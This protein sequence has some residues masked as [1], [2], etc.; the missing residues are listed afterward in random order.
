MTAETYWQQ[1]LE[2]SQSA[3]NS[4]ALV[5]LATDLDHLVGEAGITYELRHLKGVPPRHLRSA[6]P[7]PNPFR[8]WDRALEVCEVGDQHVLILNKYPVQIGHM[9]LITRQWAPQ[10]GWLNLK[11]WQALVTVDSNTTGLWFFNSGPAA[12][13]SQPHRHLQLLPRHPGESV[14]P[15]GDWFVELAASQRTTS[16]ADQEDPLR[17]TCFVHR[18]NGDQQDPI[19]LCRRY[20]DLCERAGLGSPN[21][22]EKPSQPYNLLLSRHW[23]VLVRRRCDGVRGFS[24]NAL[25]FA[26]YLLSTEASERSWLQQI[27]PEG[28]LRNVVA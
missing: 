27:G 28:L 12:G 19:Q 17:Q 25:G 26:G 6:G 24:V 3:L 21:H 22:T 23:L 4:A 1:A 18:L 13:A 5:P 9:L 2:C 7:K 15:R 20:E 11:D 16:N 8:P 14:C 10:S